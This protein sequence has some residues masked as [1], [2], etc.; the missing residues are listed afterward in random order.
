M[1]V[2]AAL[3][4]TLRLFFLSRLIVWY[5]SVFFISFCTHHEWESQAVWQI[6]GCE[7]ETC[8]TNSGMHM[9]ATPFR[10]HE[11]RVIL[12]TQHQHL[13]SL[14]FSYVHIIALVH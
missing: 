13:F 7:E 10:D 2:W 9:R 12:L 8:F 3:Y 4:E 5:L 11:V 1:W 6:E 14:F